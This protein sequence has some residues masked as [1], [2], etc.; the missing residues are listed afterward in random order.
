MNTAVLL[1]GGSGKRMGGLLPDK[2]LAPICGNQSALG[3]CIRAFDESGCVT[4]IVITCRDAAQ[5]AEIAALVKT[6]SPKARVEFVPG[7]AERQD[8]V[9]SALEAIPGDDGLVFIH[10]AARPLVTPGDIRTLRDIAAQ[11]GAAALAHPVTDT[12][13]RVEGDTPVAPLAD[14][15]RSELRA[16]E[17][18]Q[19]FALAAIRKAYRHVKETGGKVTDDA[20]AAATLGIHPA[21]MNAT[22]ANPKL[23]TPADVE[24]VRF[25]LFGE[26]SFTGTMNNNLPPYRIGFGYD[27]HRFASGRR[28]VLGGVE[29]PHAKGLEGHSDADCLCHAIADAILGAA[30][31]P[32][33][34]HYFP[35]GK[36]ET[37]DMDSLLIVQGA[38]AHA[39]QKGLSVGNIDATLIAREPKIAPH[40]AAMKEKLSCAL[41]I[42]ADRIGIKATTNEGIDGLGQGEGIAAHAV[43]ML[44]EK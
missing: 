21:L 25:L 32:D 5:Q 44:F 13:K 35:P 38:V 7:G 28:L 9:L 31:L 23:T 8:S 26:T 41:G 15:P 19:V 34:G 20:A 40:V 11:H 42:P 10:D 2:V 30:G 39:A 4:Q 27:I 17:T 24:W 3:M 12:I 33:I 1:A 22:H 43:A 29:I 36:A 14:L 37:K 18:P 16:M 6:L